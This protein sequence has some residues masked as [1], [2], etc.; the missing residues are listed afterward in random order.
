M[1]PFTAFFVTLTVSTFSFAAEFDP[2]QKILDK[3]L[4][5]QSVGEGFQSAFNY[6]EAIKDKEVGE[7]IKKQIE[8]LSKKDLSVLKTKNEA[9]AF[10]INSYN[11]YMIHNILQKGFESGKLKIKGVKDLG[12]FFNPYKVFKKEINQIGGKEMSLDQIEKGTLLGKIYKKK[13]WK[14]AR[15][16]FAVNCASKGCPPLIAKV[17]T[18]VTL[19]KTLDEN[20]QT[21]LKTPRHLKINGKTLYLTH[22]FKWYEQDFIEHSGSVKEFIYKYVSKEVQNQVDKTKS[23]EYIEYD[24]NLNKL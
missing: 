12:N 11:F 5:I 3:H 15:I 9:L 13:G 23:I 14:D 24:W 17:Y 2:F 7:N 4:V 22:L 16:H 20:I 18:A 6:T 19:D 10:W 21:A 8:I 1:I